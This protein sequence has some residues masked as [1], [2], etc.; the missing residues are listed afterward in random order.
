MT[1]FSSRQRYPLHQGYNDL[2]RLLMR[3]VGSTG[4]A[5]WHQSRTASHGPL[6]PASWPHWWPQL[7]AWLYLLHLFKI[8]FHHLFLEGSFFLLAWKKLKPGSKCVVISNKYYIKDHSSHGWFPFLIISTLPGL[9]FCELAFVWIAIFYIFWQLAIS[10][11]NYLSCSS[12]V[13]GLLWRAVE[14]HRNLK[15]QMISPNE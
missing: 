9:V 14:L 8:T 2:I 15:R 10:F 5:A 3:L 12:V 11:A 7:S 4:R 6:Q 13:C 1:I